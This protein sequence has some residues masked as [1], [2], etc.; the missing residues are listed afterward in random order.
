M[1]TEVRIPM[2]WYELMLFQLNISERWYK[3]GNESTDPFAQFFFYFTGFN[4]LYFLWSRIDDIKNEQGEPAGEGKQIS[5]LLQKL[6]GEKAGLVIVELQSTLGYFSQRRPI[7]RMDKR[8]QDSASIGAE[9]EG[10][11]WRQQLS[12]GKTSIERLER[13]MNYKLSVISLRYEPKS[14]S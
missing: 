14:L 5:N 10:R 3:R 1:T 13:V 11:K 2:K 6:S 12:E 7:Q 4:S 8:S 9:G